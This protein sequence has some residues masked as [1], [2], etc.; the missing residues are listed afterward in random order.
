MED[1]SRLRIR[2][3]WAIVR[4]I[5]PATAVFTVLQNF[6]D[7]ANTSIEWPWYHHHKT[8]TL[9]SFYIQL[10]LAIRLFVCVLSCL[11]LDNKDRSQRNKRQSIDE[12][13][14]AEPV[15]REKLFVSY[16][17]SHHKL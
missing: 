2:Q 7:T 17:Q 11:I 15:F 14:T 5:L 12:L 10:H 3:N 8:R 1:R 13:Y 9:T 6:L 16:Q 4:E